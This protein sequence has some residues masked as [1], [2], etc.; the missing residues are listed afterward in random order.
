MCVCVCVCDVFSILFQYGI[1]AFAKVFNE[2]PVTAVHINPEVLHL[3]SM[4]SMA[5]I[6]LIA[7]GDTPAGRR[8]WN[9]IERNASF[10]YDKLFFPDEN[11]A[12]CLFINGTVLH[13]TEDEYPESF[14]VWETL[15]M[16]RIALPNSELSKADGSLTCCSVRIN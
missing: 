5:G 2:W 1:E 3:K 14:K 10:S 16:P 12:N 15:D 13:V 9:D 7:I 4:S 6:D 11:G 8:A